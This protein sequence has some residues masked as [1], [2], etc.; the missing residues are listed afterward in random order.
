MRVKRA[1]RGD[2][3]IYRPPGGHVGGPLR[4]MGQLGLN[5]G[6]CTGTGISFKETGFSVA[7]EF[8]LL[9]RILYHNKSDALFVGLLLV[10]IWF[11]V[12]MYV[13]ILYFK[14]LMLFLPEHI[15]NEQFFHCNIIAIIKK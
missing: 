10:L 9:F 5:P 14:I 4:S 13:Y 7:S 11:S 1:V 2:P 3:S 6:S 15:L 8:I 12:C